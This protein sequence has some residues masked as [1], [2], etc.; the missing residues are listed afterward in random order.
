M[1][2]TH[3]PRRPTQDSV[4]T[5]R[6]L[7]GMLRNGYRSA[8]FAL[9]F[10]PSTGLSQLVDIGIDTVPPEV[11]AAILVFFRAADETF[12]PSLLGWL[13]DA[14][15]LTVEARLRSTTAPARKVAAE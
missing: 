11:C 2:A 3:D 9:D 6:L 4:T 8:Y 1:T 12:V 14:T 10:D 13:E 5:E 15:G 7:N